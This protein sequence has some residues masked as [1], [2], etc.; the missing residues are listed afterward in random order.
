MACVLMVASATAKAANPAMAKAQAS[1]A[2]TVNADPGA[3]AFQFDPVGKEKFEMHVP[4]HHD[5]SGRGLAR[6]VV[7]WFPACGGCCPDSQLVVSNR[8]G[9]PLEGRWQ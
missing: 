8:Q 7:V 2:V 5:H 3:C 6:Q 9:E 4:R 1:A